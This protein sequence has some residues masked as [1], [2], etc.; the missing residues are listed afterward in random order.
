MKNNIIS[1]FGIALTTLLVVS[2]NTNG[3]SQQDAQYSIYMFNPLAVNHQA[4][5][6]TEFRIVFGGAGVSN[7][8][9]NSFD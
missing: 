5:R 2:I 1:T 7:G 3:I 9:T 6:R 4:N 8:S